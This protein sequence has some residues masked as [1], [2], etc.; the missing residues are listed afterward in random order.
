MVT[1]RRNRSLRGAAVRAVLWG[2]A[3]SA[4]AAAAVAQALQVDVRLE[5]GDE[6]GLDELAILTIR[7]DSAGALKAGPGPEFEVEN[8]Q[9]AAGPSKSNSLR[10]SGGVSSRSLT[11]TWHLQPL[12]VGSARVHSG[13]LT[14]DGE[15]IRLPERRVEVRALAPAERRRRRPPD[16]PSDPFFTNDPF[17]S[18]L[19]AG[20]GRRRRPRPVEPPRI[21]LSAEATP[22]DPYVGEQVLYTLYLFTQA[23]VRSVNPE[24]LPDFKGFW[25]RVVPQPE[26]LRPQMLYLDGERIGKVVLLQR[27][28]F[29]RRA[30]RF[31]IGSVRARMSADV[32]DAGPFGSLVPRTREIVR[33][34]NAVTVEV[35]ELP[36]PPLL[37]QGAVGQVKLA[38]DLA[39]RQ[40]EV[41]EAATLSLTLKGRG[42]FQG[43]PPPLLPEL[44]GV[45]VFPPQ[46]LSSEAVKRKEVSGERT[47][48]F[49]LVPQRPGRWDLPAIEVPYFDPRQER[50]LVAR[51]PALDLT[52]RGSR[53]LAFEDGRTVSLHPIRTAALPAAGGRRLAGLEPWLFA[54]PWGL[55][56]GL[57][58]A[59]RRGGGRLGARRRLLSRLD[60]ALAE[61]APRQAAVEIEEAWRDFLYKRWGLD[62]GAPSTRW[63]ALLLAAGARQQAAGELM[64]L[65]DDLHYL[66]YAPQLSST[67]GLRRELVERSRRL[68]RALG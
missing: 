37:F 38:A 23:D 10:F 58:L 65:A 8:F 54:L 11:F 51:T 26:Q 68:A 32:P 45:E 28:L 29:P 52:V 36:P 40:L 44:P 43:L 12:E 24:E 6:I 13:V 1:A 64:A 9:V 62:R 7:I 5:P 21:Y 60:G 25:A 46:Q 41:G 14:I 3:L 30:G 34:S 35:R 59:R 27:A 18:L 15:E 56:V 48:S 66:R 57:L 53:R 17:E 55:A 47:W 19:D 31:E 50:Y 2:L 20:R 49:V 33:A 39:P 16:P 4:A 61:T 63:S 67:D 22:R 42:H